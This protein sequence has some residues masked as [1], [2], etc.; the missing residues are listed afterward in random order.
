MKRKLWQ[1]M[2]LLFVCMT[3]R[4]YDFNV[5][6]IHYNFIANNDN[7]VSV[8]GCDDGMTIVN[9]PSRVYYGGG[10]LHVTEIGESAFAGYDPYEYTPGCCT[11]TLPNSIEIIRAKAFFDCNLNPDITLP[12]SLRVIEQGAFSETSIWTVNIP[13]SVEQIG[14][15]A[16]GGTWDDCPDN[17]ESYC[18][19]RYPGKYVVDSRNQY[20]SSND[21]ILYDKAKTRIIDIPDG[22]VGEINIPNTV[23]KCE[24]D[25]ASGVTKIWVAA[26]TW[27][28]MDFSRSNLPYVTYKKDEDD[29]LIYEYGHPAVDSYII[30]DGSTPVGPVNGEVVLPEGVER[31]GAFLFSSS[32]GYYHVCEYMTSVTIPNSVTSIG[33]YAF[34]GCRCLTSVVSKI[35]EPFTI[36]SSAFEGIASTCTLT[37]PYGTKDAYIAH[38][39]TTSVFKGGIVEAPAPTVLATGVSLNKTAVTLNSV[40]QTAT[41]IATVAP[42]NVSNSNVT[43]T[44][45][46]NGVATVSNTGIVTAV[47]NGTATITA[48]T[49]DGTDL[50]ATCAVTVDISVSI[51][52]ADAN[53]KAICLA[54]WDT[55]GDDELSME[56]AAAVTDLGTVFKENTTIT[57]FDELQYFTGLESICDEAFNG[58]SNLASVVLPEGLKNINHKSFCSTGLKSIKFPASLEYAGDQAF[59]DSPLENIDFNGCAATFDMACFQGNN[60]EDLYIPNTVK[61]VGYNNL[62]WSSLKHVTFEAFEEGQEPWK[63]PTLLAGCVHLES[64][65]L[66]TTAVM[67]GEFLEICWDLTSITILKVEDNF[68]IMAQNYARI[69]GDVPY[70]NYVK[71]NIPEGYAEKFLRAGYYNLSDLGGLPFAREEFESEAARISLMADQLSGGDKGALTTAISNARAIV[72]AAGDYLTIY[73]QIDAIKDAA[74]IYVNS[75][76]LTKGDDLTAAY[77]LNPEFDHF[78]FGW[79]IFSGYDTRGVNFGNRR[80]NGGVSIENFVEAQCGGGLGDGQIAQTITNLP[81]GIYRLE[82]DAQADTWSE[83][84][85]V[86]GTTFFA[87]TSSIPVSTKPDKPEHFSVRFENPST[88]SVTVGINLASSNAKYVSA[89]N[90]RLYYEGEV[91]P[92]PAG[93]E[94]V[95]SEDDT[96]YIYNVEAGMF[97]NAGNSW[98]THALLAET[99]LPVRMTQDSDGYWEIFFRKGSH[100][101]QK[102]FVA[103]DSKAVYVDWAGGVPPRWLIAPLDGSY[104]IQYMSDEGTSYVLGNDPNR[105]DV[106]WQNNTTFDTHIDVIRT[107]NIANHTRWQFIKAAD[108]DLAMAKRQ[109]FVTICRMEQSDV[110]NDDLLSNGEA[111]YYDAHATL[112]EVIEA[113]TLLNS[114]MGMP[115]ENAPV[116][117]TAII[118]NPAFEKN[119]TEGW[120]DATRGSTDSRVQEFN[121]TSFN[122]YQQIVGVPNGRY[123]LKYKGYHRAGSD[124]G[125]ASAVVYAND[126]QKTLKRICDGA[127]DTQLLGWGELSYNGQWIPDYRSASRKYFDAG[128]YADYL[129]VEVTD[130]TLTIGVK[131]TEEMGANHRVCFSDFELEILEN[132]AQPQNK[133]MDF[134]VEVAQ[135]RVGVASIEMKNVDPITAFQFEVSVPEGVTLTACELT[136][137]R[138]APAHTISYRKLANGNYQIVTNI[139]LDKP[140][141][142]GTEGALVN[143]VLKADAAMVEGEYDVTIKNI[144]LTTNKVL[145]IRP[146]DVHGMMTVINSGGIIVGDVNGTGTVTITDAVAIVS[147]ILG[148]DIDGFVSAAA[149]VTGDGRITITDAV[150]IVDMILHG[151]ASSKGRAG[152]DEDELDPQ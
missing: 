101:Q 77:I 69:L 26:K 16:F 9:I 152:M 25:F 12:T 99:G 33:K 64:V 78:Q 13:E 19:A 7:N 68:D 110:D 20:F 150:A 79:S 76:T 87:G 38:G 6:G 130:N 98:G 124:T 28:E 112:A 71:V 151:S 102:L 59:R 95:S 111:V 63:V 75:T 119:T 48:T 144:E 139:S 86:T 72:N 35:E 17:D 84:V 121:Q 136:K 134:E 145:A 135:G 116:D 74:K 92:P 60:V 127:S 51:A 61:F 24:D 43:W 142:S 21:G 146:S 128:L 91:A 57:S 34:S 58:C 56:E 10:W 89:D 66:P 54:N 114:Q 115:K 30:Y 100:H 132:A 138:K 85:P 4:A 67:G 1:I 23:K 131:N 141:F 129:E 41:L 73:A 118:I 88:Q 140:V 37:V 15:G 45:S 27:Y 8:A 148:E 11:F 147:H 149:D 14:A 29:N 137:E 81:A 39:W 104:T 31:L 122:M 83:E 50:A 117:M 106:D 113:I 44:S 36:Y 133:L 65:V 82:I 126:V 109:L 125:D 40:G 49:D 62:S 47:A 53:V 93:T 55:D 42:D 70:T 18:W 96:Y 3:G 143:L 105:Q 46:N 103:D 108:Y 94:L 22:F 90:F 32:S 97:L 107:N 5:D 120:T 80:E 123:R 52:F 2:L